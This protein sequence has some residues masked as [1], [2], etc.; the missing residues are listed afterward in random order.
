MFKVHAN[1]ISNVHELYRETWQQSKVADKITY[2]HILRCPQGSSFPGPPGA[3]LLGQNPQSLFR[4][5]LFD[6][7]EDSLAVKERWNKCKS[8]YRVNLFSFLFAIHISLHSHTPLSV[9][10]G[11]CWPACK[12]WIQTNTN[13]RKQLRKREKGGR[14]RE[15][16][17]QM[18]TDEGDHSR[19]RSPVSFTKC[20]SS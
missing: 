10:I 5:S 14:E 20:S 8:Y 2:R 7:A 18:G 3:G 1:H 17:G 16:E 4:E 9:S 6:R 15:R 11:F 12:L 13:V 19:M